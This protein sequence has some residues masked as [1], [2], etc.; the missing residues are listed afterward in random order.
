MMIPQPL[1]VEALREPARAHG[2]SSWALCLVG[3]LA[4]ALAC[5]GSFDNNEQQS[6]LRPRASTPN[7]GAPDTPQGSASGS[8]IATPSGAASAGEGNDNVMGIEGA[9]STGRSRA[10]GTGRAR[11]PQDDVDAGD[12]VEADA[13]AVDAGDDGGVVAVDAGDDGGA[14]PP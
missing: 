11:P 10:G 9:S 5:T 7:G 4:G 12:E 3:L 13:G 6:S 1:P 2:A 8:S 14:A